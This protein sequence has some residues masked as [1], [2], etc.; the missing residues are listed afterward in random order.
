MRRH[1]RLVIAVFLVV[2]AV[3]APTPAATGRVRAAGVN[4]MP[5]IYDIDFGSALCGW[6][7][8]VGHI[9]TAMH[10]G[11]KIIATTD[12]GATWKFQTVPSA[13]S[14]V[15]WSVAAGSATN[16]VAV[17]DSGAIVYTKNGGTTWN[18][19]SGTTPDTLR[20]VAYA[21]EDVFVAVGLAGGG[22]GVVYRSTDGGATW[23]R[24]P[25]PDVNGLR[26][27]AFSGASG[28]AGGS[29]KGLRTIDHGASW[30]LTEDIL[31]TYDMA[32]VGD[33]AWTFGATS[34]NVGTV[35]AW[36]TNQFTSFN[37]G[38]GYVG[39]GPSAIVVRASVRANGGWAVGASGSASAY[40]GTPIVFKSTA[41]ATSWTSISTPC[42]KSATAVY[43]QDASNV[44]V[45]GSNKAFESK[46]IH[47]TDGGA[48]WKDV[49][50]STSAPV[51]K[52][53]A[54]LK[55]PTVSP[56]TPSRTRAFKVSGTLSPAM[57]GSVS[58]RIYRRGSA[59]IYTKKTIALSKRGASSAYAW[60]VKL[61]AGA[62]T[63]RTYFAGNSAY[64][65]CTSS[66][67]TFVVK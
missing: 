66:A 35:F 27:V 43:C 9:D 23:S 32:Y 47:S 8:G 24:T 2:G 65:T 34:W 28:V 7:V 36:S 49:A 48:S 67:K 42:D 30:Q 38:Y 60:S 57:S 1:F 33:T 61:P 46:L 37:T 50:L 4:S 53:S 29:G 45:A 44:W 11:G 64:K 22:K 26:G 52:K 19:V 6:A 58:V 13:G 15:L 25:R 10:S 39:A 21:G 59:A 51:V 5:G 12:G 55:S 3:I 56:V 18:R 40:T 31:T 41:P 62:W 20:G 63:V 16:A 17:G 54:Y 14:A